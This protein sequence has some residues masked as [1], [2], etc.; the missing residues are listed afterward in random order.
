MTQ[1]LKSCPERQKAI[2]E[3][4]QKIKGIRTLYHLRVSDA[5]S[6]YYWLHLEMQ[7]DA[8]LDDLDHYLRAIWLECCDHLSAFR[9]GDV[10]YFS[11][12]PP[13]GWGQERDMNVRARRI[14]SPGMEFNYEY[15]FG[16]T[17]ELIIKVLDVRKGGPLSSRPLFL[18]ARNSLEPLPCSQCDQPAT[19]LCTSCVDKHGFY[20]LFCEQ[21]AAEHG[22]KEAYH[23]EYMMG[24]WNSPRTGQCGY[25]GPAEPPY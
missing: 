16:T 10:F 9:I 18:M 11:Y 13:G 1:H 2:A 6:G 4:D 12:P 3:A 21:H 7:G 5:W 20:L 19:Q 14:L 25:E 8:T 22:R 23:F 17:T 24:I 15:D